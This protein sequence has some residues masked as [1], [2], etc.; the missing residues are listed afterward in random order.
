MK[1]NMDNLDSVYDYGLLSEL[2]AYS[3]RTKAKS[4]YLKCIHNKKYTLAHKIMEKYVI[5]FD[6]GDS[7]TAMQYALTHLRERFKHI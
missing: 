7:I 6:H 5:T 3:V 4:V 2:Y 1:N